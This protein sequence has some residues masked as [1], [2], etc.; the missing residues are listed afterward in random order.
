[1]S[2]GLRL[3]L[4]LSRRSSGSSSPP[5]DPDPDPE[6]ESREFIMGGSYYNTTASR[7]VVTSSGYVN[8]G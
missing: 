2:R 8:E 4:G 5:P 1:M 6:F 3:G 7:Q